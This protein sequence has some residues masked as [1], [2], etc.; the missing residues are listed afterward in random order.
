MMNPSRESCS[1]LTMNGGSSSI[2]FALYDEVEPLRQRLNGKLD[3]VGLSGTNLTFND[4]SGQ[5]QDNRTIDSPPI[6]ALRSLSYLIGSK[7]S[8]CLLRSKP[9]VIAWSM[10]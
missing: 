2:R 3:R 4:P 10:G 6:T 1:L 7:R 8:K 5:S 9:L